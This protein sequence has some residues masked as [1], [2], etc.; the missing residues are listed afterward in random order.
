MISLVKKTVSDIYERFFGFSPDIVIA[1]TYECNES[2]RYCYTKGLSRDMPGFISI[3]NFSKVIFWLKKQGKNKVMLFGGEPTIHPNFKKIIHILK[4]NSVKYVL[5]TNGCFDNE[6]LTN[7][8]EYKPVAVQVN[9]RPGLTEKNVT[10]LLSKSIKV[11]LRYNIDDIHQDNHTIISFAKS[12]NLPIIFGITYDGFQTKCMGY[13]IDSG[14]ALVNF[15]KEASSNK[16]NSFLAGP[17]PR[18]LFNNSEWDLLKKS[19]A[20]STCEPLNSFGWRKGARIVNPDL[21][22]F[23]C[24]HV[25]KKAPSLI[26]FS[27]IDKLNEYFK[28]YIEM[29]KW[30]NFLYEKCKT[31]NYFKNKTCQGGCIGSK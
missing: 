8:Y 10:N 1:L 26:E 5:V 20:S 13:S 22:V 27:S 16:L 7:L 28:D 15:A 12:L 21:S 25:F 29:M 23:A 19:G 17:I 24:F 4:Q 30:E 31:C 2:C 6:I 18:C 3:D 14:K 11:F 9:Y